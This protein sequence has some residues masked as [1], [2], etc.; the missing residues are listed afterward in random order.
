MYSFKYYACNFAN[1]SVNWSVPHGQIMCWIW[2]AQLMWNMSMF[3][4]DT[5]RHCFRDRPCQVI[6]DN[7]T[8][9]LAEWGGGK[10]IFQLFKREGR[11]VKSKIM[12]IFIDSTCI[13]HGIIY[14]KR[15]LAT[16]LV[17]LRL[18]APFFMMEW[19]I[20]HLFLYTFS[21]LVEIYMCTDNT[22][23]GFLSQYGARIILH[24]FVFVFTYQY[25]TQTCKQ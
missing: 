13:L 9:F 21:L 24:K 20:T 6:S 17:C 12:S 5:D 16:P 8:P 10:N 4:C 3:P 15:S 11:T 14:M 23:V 22:Y 2:R 18:L 19:G 1:H 25:I 7:T